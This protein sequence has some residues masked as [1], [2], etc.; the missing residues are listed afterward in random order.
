[1]AT[2]GFVSQLVSLAR[3]SRQVYPRQ[4]SQ[5]L[6]N[7]V[8][9]PPKIEDGRTI[10]VKRG[11]PSLVAVFLTSNNGRFTFPDGRTEERTWKAGE[12]MIMPAEE[13]LPEKSERQF[14]WKWF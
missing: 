3:A 14:R 12:S 10:Q 7:R 9:C 8:L 2:K 1:M 6:G 4:A 13:H 11:H 5:E